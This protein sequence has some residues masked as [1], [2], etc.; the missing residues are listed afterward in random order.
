ME[1]QKLLFVINNLEGGGAEKAL[2]TILKN[3]DNT[4]YDITLYLLFKSGVY[5]N[6][7]PEEVKLKFLF[8][9]KK[10]AILMKIIKKFIKYLSP[11]LLYKLIVKERYD[12][13]IAF[14]EGIPTK[15]I[16]GSNS[17]SLKIA[18]VHTNLK[19]Y[20][21]V[22]NLYKDMVEMENQYNNFN[23]IV[24]VSKDSKDSFEDMFN[25]SSNLSVVLNPIDSNE[26]ALKS[27]ENIQKDNEITIC[28]VGRL[29][30]EKGYDRLIRA[31]AKLVKEGFS[32][33]VVIVGDGMLR[34]QLEGLAK[35][36]GV[37]NSVEFKGFQSNP[38]KFMK[39][40]DVFIN[41]SRTEGFALVVGEAILLD[42]PV[43]CTDSGGPREIIEDG[44]YGLLVENSEE[45]IYMGL[46]KFLKDAEFRS[47]LRCVSKKRKSFFDISDNLK[48]I[49]SLFQNNV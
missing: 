36:L 4:R 6:D 12:I 38:Y 8:K 19:K 1:K 33:K 47:W 16:A 49:E 17:S 15:I 18:W 35:G 21:W 3:L 30:Y 10:N 28:S 13:E 44:K 40:S 37:Q 48:T 46:K 24:F 41:C 26:I 27:I 22:K 14:L 32:H 29:S 43:I 7:V 39:N 11:K 23:R 9:E 5:L 31:H 34:T 42:L 2:V 25:V 45:G 20:N